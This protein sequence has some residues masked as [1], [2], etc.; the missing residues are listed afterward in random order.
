MTKHNIKNTQK[1]LNINDMICTPDFIVDFLHQ[2]ILP[3][4]KKSK[5]KLKIFNPAW[6]GIVNLAT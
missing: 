5:N 6:S 2:K 4:V 3:H 1:P